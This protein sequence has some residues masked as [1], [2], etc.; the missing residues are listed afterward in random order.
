MIIFISCHECNSINSINGIN[1]L[2]KEFFNE[3]FLLNVKNTRSYVLNQIFH[4]FLLLSLMLGMVIITIHVCSRFTYI[5]PL[6]EFFN[7][8][9]LLNVKKTLLLFYPSPLEIFFK[10]EICHVNYLKFMLMNIKNQLT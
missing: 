6:K 9:F 2:L 10:K 7:E 1:C 3:K 8:K 5:C 4:C